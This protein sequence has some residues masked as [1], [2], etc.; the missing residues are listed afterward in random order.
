MRHL[1]AKAETTASSFLL[2]VKL[3]FLTLP[4]LLNEGGKEMGPATSGTSVTEY[5]SLN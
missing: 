4:S 1:T 2:V 5:F 3:R